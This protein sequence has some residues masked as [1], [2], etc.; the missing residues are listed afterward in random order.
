MK[1]LAGLEVMLQNWVEKRLVK[2]IVSGLWRKL[3]SSL[4]PGN[5]V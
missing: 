5:I 3:S 4:Y 1:N 2:V